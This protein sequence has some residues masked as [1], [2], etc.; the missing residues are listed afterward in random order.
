M[1]DDISTDEMTTSK[2]ELNK[3][4]R[5]RLHEEQYRL[6]QLR[7]ESTRRKLY[8]EG[9]MALFASSEDL[10]RATLKEL[11]VDKDRGDDETSNEHDSILDEYRSF[12]LD[13]LNSFGVALAEKDT[14]SDVSL[15]TFQSLDTLFGQSSFAD[16]EFSSKFIKMGRRRKKRD[17][18]EESL[19]QNIKDHSQAVEMLA[20]EEIILNQVLGD[21]KSNN[22]DFDE[23]GKIEQSLLQLFKADRSKIIKQENAIQRARERAASLTKRIENTQSAL[24]DIEFPLAQEDYN[25][26]TS[27]LVRISSQIIPDLAK[28]IKSRH[29]DFE[30]LRQLEEHTDLT[31]PQV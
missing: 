20:K 14:E 11:N 6:A 17:D 2:E 10:F 27:E 13:S 25:N 9:W 28:F 8:S 16:P 23:L 1:P 22:H 31:K 29:S 26:A 24:N 12:Y 30:K 4:E 18:L 15:A 7:K 3:A 19:M 21:E 5:R